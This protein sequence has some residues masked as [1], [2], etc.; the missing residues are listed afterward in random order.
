MLLSEY[1]GLGSLLDHSGVFDPDLK[2]DS[3]FFINIQRLKETHVPEFVHSYDSIHDHF[4]EIIKLLEKAR[5]KDKTDIFFKSAVKRFNFSE[6]NGICLGYA[7][8]TVGA[9]FGEKLREDVIGNA[10]EIVK[11]GVCDPEFFELL[12][13]FQE[14]V[15]ADRLSDMIAT[16]ILPD[17]KLF[18]KRINQELGIDPT[19]YEDVLFN[20]GYL[21]NPY[22]N[23]NLLLVPT[24]ILHKLP[25]VK[26]WEEI[27]DV[28][29]TNEFVRAEMNAEVADEWRKHTAAKK[30]N[31]LKRVIFEKPAAFR[32]V[33]KGYQSETIDEFTADMDIEY[34]IKK[35]TSLA[36]KY[37]LEQEK[38]P[39]DSNSL[40]A[41]ENMLMKFKHWV[42]Y[43][44]GW[45]VIQNANSRNKEKIV[46]VI[47]QLAAD[48][49]DKK[50]IWDISRESDAG[51]G[52]VDFKV[53]RGSDKTVIEVKLSSNPQY[54]HGY[55]KQIEEYAKA[56]ET[57]K[58][59]Y[60]FIDLGN[61]GRAKQLKDF[62]DQEYNDGR[63]P[64]ELIIVDA[65]C[66][67]SAS[68]A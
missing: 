17:I 37:F 43:K 46:Q 41:A 21:V 10:Y 38:E 59:I 12:P 39:R 66:R 29:S 56:E 35:L 64:P 68:K 4:R 47:I 62:H 5:R 1:L 65:T 50:H 44:R 11:A 2:E 52:P 55:T 27:D 19:H 45:E 49:Y 48:C 28:V 67:K 57:D 25:V 15:G 14:N 58:R 30:K 51:R 53:S 9:G 8:G 42:E 60:V 61:P 34:C 20:D 6:V 54:L 7:K 40:M 26:S 13:L 33:I 23:D 18:T 3:H 24:D 31:Y 32:R 22:K 63:N 16:L 36:K